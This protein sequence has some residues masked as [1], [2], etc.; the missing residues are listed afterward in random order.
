MD[1]RRG[2]VVLMEAFF[3]TPGDVKHDSIVVHGDE[4]HHMIHVMRKHPGDVVLLTDGEGTMFDTVLKSVQGDHAL[5]AIVNRQSE[6]HE[7][8]RKVCLLQAVLKQPG[9]MDW[10]IEK[11]TEL[12]VA[13]IIPVVTERTIAKSGKKERW[14]SI[15]RTAAK[16]SL[17][18]RIPSIDDVQPL[19][20][21][22]PRVSGHTLFVCHE[23]DGTNW[24]SHSF[25]VEGSQ[26]AIGIGPE[27]GF[28]QDEI[29]TF[30]SNG[31]EIVS[32]GERRLRSETAAIVA[33]THLLD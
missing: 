21:A 20:Q 13:R 5:C 10:L 12:G 23:G 25:A 19:E 14:L 4:F 15:A 2:S 6:Y 28:T 24:L 26:I 7:P 8:R 27:G 17:R 33:L 31:A 9:R 16:Q 30:T 18:S 22:I 11:A 29:T 32:L 1:L 3:I